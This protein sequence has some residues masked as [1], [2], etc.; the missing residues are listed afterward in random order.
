MVVL[1]DE[2]EN[3]SKTDARNREPRWIYTIE[4]ENSET[5]SLFFN[6]PSVERHL[7][8]VNR[9]YAIVAEQQ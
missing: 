8:I 7:C 2:N 6:N 3:S 5:S 1:L 4:Y 9:G